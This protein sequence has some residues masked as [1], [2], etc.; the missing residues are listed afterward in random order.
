LLAP[1]SF[2]IFTNAEIVDLFR[3]S[4]VQLGSNNA[5]HDDI[6]KCIKAMQRDSF[7]SIMTQLIVRSKANTFEMVIIIPMLSAQD[8]LHI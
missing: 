6:I 2:F 5:Q 8:N 4:R 1:F 7:C 3:T